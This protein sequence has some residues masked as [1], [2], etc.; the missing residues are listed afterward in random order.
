M[1]QTELAA[2]PELDG[3]HP[4]EIV[5][6]TLATFPG[7]TALTLSFGGGGVVLAHIVSR[8][9][10]TVP[11]IFIDTGMH[12]PETYAFKQEFAERYGLN[13]I[14]VRPA[15]DPGPLYGTDPDGCCRIRKVEPLAPVIARFDAWI[16]GLRRDQSPT[17]AGLEPVARHEVDGRSIVKVFPLARWSREDVL[18]YARVH[19]I[20]RHPLLDRGYTSIG[21]WPCTHATGPGEA[22][23]AG[24]WSGTGK[25]ECGL[26][27]FTARGA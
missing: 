9:D 4:E 3:A 6:W 17:R 11:V 10:R 12:F 18:R 7:R 26:H 24:R 23:R 13:L 22:E 25:L 19:D 20:P 15:S 16:S 8:I 2:A 21:C 1:S 27:T 14:E 5:A